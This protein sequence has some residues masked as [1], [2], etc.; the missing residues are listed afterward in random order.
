V[1]TETD[2][3]HASGLQFT[4]H[5]HSLRFSEPYSTLSG[6]HTE[7][8][9]GP[10]WRSAFDK[11]VIPIQPNNRPPK[12]AISLPSG[13]VQYF[14]AAGTEMYNYSGAAGS[15][16]VVAGTGFFYRGPDSTERLRSC[17]L[18]R[19]IISTRRGL[20]QTLPAAQ[21]GVGISRNRSVT[22]RLT[23]IRAPLARSTY[24]YDYRDKRTT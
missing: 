11:R 20:Y 16:A 10:A 12:H 18:L 9:L 4:R 22:T 17:I 19:S 14:D 8:R 2:Y 7:N 1:E 21:C 6:S 13:G 15:L 5:Y 23:R 3:R 24:R